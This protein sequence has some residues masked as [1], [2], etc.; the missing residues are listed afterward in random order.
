M[1]SADFQTK[2]APS[3][4][5]ASCSR[6]L[7]L[8]RTGPLAALAALLLIAFSFSIIAYPTQTEAQTV[9]ADA[10]LS[11]LTVSPRDIIGFDAGRK[12][13]HLGVAG[14]VER[15][16]ITATPNHSGATVAYNT[17]DA[18][19]DTPGH[20]MDLHAG[21]NTVIITVTAQ[22]TVSTDR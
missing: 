4:K 2:G 14:T 7:T 13:Y 16:T 22:D 18:D 8:T 1:P 5:F 12:I 20:Q 11:A 9:S 10:T 21:Y 3:L 15:V 19:T 6:V 17:T